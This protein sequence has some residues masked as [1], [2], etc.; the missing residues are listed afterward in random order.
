MKSQARKTGGLA[1]AA[2]T[3]IRLLRTDHLNDQL[4]ALAWLKAQDFV[5]P[6]RIAVAGNSLGGVESVLGAERASYCAVVDVS[7]GAESWTLSPELQDLMTQAVRNSRAPILF[8][9]A[10]NDYDLSP[11][12]EL[13]AAMKDAGKA[14]EVKIYPAYGASAQ[15]GHSFAYRGSAVWADD[16]FGF[17]EKHCKP[18]P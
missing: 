17:L 14:Y 7:G 3:M 4:A 18:V 15:E 1:A 11:S 10:A 2:A 12:R 9:Q 6:E 16:V 5:A 13:S 8:F